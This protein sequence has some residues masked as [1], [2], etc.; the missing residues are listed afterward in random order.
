MGFK[1]NYSVQDI[2]CQIRMIHHDCTNPRN[3]GFVSWGL[4][5]DLYQIKWMLDDLL[6]DTSTFAG[7]EEWLREMD[8]KKVIKILKGS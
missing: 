6:K 7:E 2:E 5:Q 4:K 1:M 3:D 8:K